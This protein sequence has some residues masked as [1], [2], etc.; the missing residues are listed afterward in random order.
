MPCNQNDHD[1]LGKVRHVVGHGEGE[2]KEPRGAPC[3]GLLAQS[4]VSFHE[5]TS[6]VL[7]ACLVAGRSLGFRVLDRFSRQA[8]PRDRGLPPAPVLSYHGRDRKAVSLV[9]M[10]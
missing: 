2:R 8:C 9:L 5:C 3:K 6:C 10:M 1:G 4:T 7:I